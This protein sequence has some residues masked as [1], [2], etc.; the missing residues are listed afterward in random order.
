MVISR[1]I[2]GKFRTYRYLVELLLGLIFFGMPWVMINGNPIFRI[3]IPARQY[4]IFGHLFIP[5]EGYFLQILF[6]LA[7]LCLFFFTTLIGRVW[8]GWACP[9]TVFTD[10]FD[11]IGRLVLGKKYGKPSAPIWGRAIIYVLWIGFAIISSMHWVGYFIDIRIIFKEFFTWSFEP[12]SVYQ[13]FILAFTGLLLL[14]MIVIR[15][16][17]CKFA[18]PYA[19]FQTVMMDEHSL[20]V[21]Y[22][23]VRGEPRRNKKEKIG[24]CTAC[25][26]CLVVCPTAI[27]IR[28]G[29]NVGC[30]ACAKCVDA[31]TIQMEK[32]NKKSLINYDTMARI[33]SNQK[34]KWI[35]TRS[36][37]YAVFL[38]ALTTFFITLLVMRKPLYLS[39][40]PDRYIQPIIAPEKKVLNV[41]KFTLI[42]NSY[43]DREVKISLDKTG[44]DLPAKLIGSESDFQLTVAKASIIQKTLYVE[45]GNIKLDD[46]LG[47]RYSI[48]IIIQD[49]KDPTIIKTAKVPVFLPDDPGLN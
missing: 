1:H 17:F 31:C 16:H 46:K 37:I 19:R 14:D 38:F 34:I 9:Q 15:E 18:C 29:L 3:D 49:I 2:S 5:Q 13:Y 36:I 28:E 30:I 32:E 27:D 43:E 21:T 23:H 4:H 7:G 8:C 45:T 44:F 48:Q 33:E 6:I 47:K 10:Y 24:D 22:D 25:N 20:N 41:Y 12:L 11:L 26:M 42:N 40:I 39:V 35:R